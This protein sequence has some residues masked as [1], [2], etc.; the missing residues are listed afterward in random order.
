[1]L[2]TKFDREAVQFWITENCQFCEREFDKN[3]LGLNIV[4]DFSFLDN[5]VMAYRGYHPECYAQRREMDKLLD[6]LL[7][8]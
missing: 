1:M 4:I 7:L 6:G 5:G 8:S 2:K 3:D